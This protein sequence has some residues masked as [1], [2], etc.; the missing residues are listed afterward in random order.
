MTRTQ[1]LTKTHPELAE[2]Q[3]LFLELLSKNA[4]DLKAVKENKFFL[5]EF[6]DYK[7]QYW[8]N[9]ESAVLH[10]CENDIPRGKHKKLTNDYIFW[11]SLANYPPDVDTSEVNNS[12][13][14]K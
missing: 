2:L 13:D 9:F 14:A 8:T 6:P 1:H 10:T 5:M 7:A 12:D 4:E 11:C 3:T